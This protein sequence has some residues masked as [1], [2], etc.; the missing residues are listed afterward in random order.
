MWRNV[1]HGVQPSTR[2][3]SSSSIGTCRNIGRRITSAKASERVLVAS[4][5]AGIVLTRP[6][7]LKI[8]NTG[9]ASRASGNTCSSR[10][11]T[12]ATSTSRVRSRLIA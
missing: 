11:V 1:C 8:R 9:V 10:T 2:E 7:D 4:T 12:S 6:I 5:T 3:A